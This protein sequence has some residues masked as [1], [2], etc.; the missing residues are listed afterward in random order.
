MSPFPDTLRENSRHAHESRAGGI[1]VNRLR[2]TIHRPVDRFSAAR[3]RARTLRVQDMD[4]VSSIDF[5]SA[6]TE[7]G[8]GAGPATGGADAAGSDS[9]W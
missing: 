4:D 7:D 1:V 9:G 2:T 5:D 6:L 8:P 3:H